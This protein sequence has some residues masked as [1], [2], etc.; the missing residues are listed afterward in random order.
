MRKALPLL[1]LPFFFIGCAE[2]PEF[3]YK[4]VSFDNLPGWQNDKQFHEI[5]HAF[6]RSCER[7]KRKKSGPMHT[8]ELFGTIE[9]WQGLCDKF[10]SLEKEDVKNFFE[11]SFKPYEVTARDRSG[12]YTGYYEP[13]LEGR[14]EQ[15][16][17]FNVPLYRRPSDL[18]S[19]N[20]GQFDD[21]LKGKSIVGRVVGSR[22]QPY[23]VREQLENGSKLSPNDV[24]IWLKDPVE[25]FF[26]HVQGSGR[27][28]LPSGRELTVGYAAHNGKPY[29]SIGRVLINNDEMKKE[30]VTMFTLKQWLVDNPDKRDQILQENDRFVFFRFTDS[31]VRGA[32]GAELTPN[33]SLAVDT[34]FVPLGVPV[35]VSTNITS[36]E[37]AVFQ[38]LMIAQDKGG[39]IKGPARGDIFFGSGEI[40][41]KRAGYQNAEGQMF[42]LLPHS[43]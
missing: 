21:D 8:N 19:V 30:D 27:V 42:I 10:S 17:E 12:L 23:H 16:S 34:S 43:S 40:A 33:R 36:E 7:I 1:L 14:F 22:L 38:K 3:E 41:E 31:G 32:Q 20:L 25:A 15:T 4:E 35:Y 6:S 5:N 29:T 24:L 2:K 26:L 37:D 39:A 11:T 18:V 13:M 9:Q 28:K